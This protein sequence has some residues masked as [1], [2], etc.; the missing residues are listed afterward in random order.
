[1]HN[2]QPLSNSYCHDSKTVAL[3][4]TP[5]QVRQM[6]ALQ[7]CLT[8]LKLS[9]GSRAVYNSGR[10]WH[11]FRH[12]GMV[13]A[14][15]VGCLLSLT[16]LLL[17]R[18]FVRAQVYE[19]PDSHPSKQVRLEMYA[20]Y[21]LFAIATLIGAACLLSHIW[22]NLHKEQNEQHYMVTQVKLDKADG[23]PPKLKKSHAQCVSE[24]EAITVECANL[25]RAL[26]REKFYLSVCP[27]LLRVPND[28]MGEGKWDMRLVIASP[29]PLSLSQFTCYRVLNEEKVTWRD[30]NYREYEEGPF[31]ARYVPIKEMRLNSVPNTLFRKIQG[32]I[33][34]FQTSLSSLYKKQ[35]A[36]SNEMVRKALPT[37][38]AVLAH[39]PADP[40]GK[41]EKEM[42]TPLVERKTEKVKTKGTATLVENKPAPQPQL[43]HLCPIFY[44]PPGSPLRTEA[45]E[46]GKALTKA[47]DTI[48][49]DSNVQMI[50]YKQLA[51][52]AVD[53]RLK[54]KELGDHLFELKQ[55]RA[56]RIYY[57]RGVGGEIFL[58]RVGT[59]DTQHSDIA[60][61]REYIRGNWLAAKDAVLRLVDS[62]PYQLDPAKL[63]KRST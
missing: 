7:N 50:I 14:A 48:I 15:F 63:P 36:H 59:K 12:R 54:G 43:S 45:Y 16:Y 21:H 24:L 61:C 30:F 42:E 20:M 6:P 58:L 22:W 31:A 18:M 47:M 37:P 2:I 25:Q 57:T 46:G 35:L 62:R 26:R 33:D 19:L 44:L 10:F 3:T 51:E 56:V 27:L 60:L 40:K 13:Q 39:L 53:Q 32:M 29:L 28:K 8:R 52:M 17:E 4:L 1:M 5:H 9:H 38:T 41:A 34:Q 55:G 23:I 11:E 49:P